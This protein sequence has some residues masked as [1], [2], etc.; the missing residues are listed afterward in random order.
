MNAACSE[1]HAAE[2]ALVAAARRHRERLEK[3][4]IV[5]VTGSCGKTTTKDLAAAILSV[6][7]TGSKNDDTRNCGADVAATL[8]AARPDDDYLVQELGAWGPGTL[9]AGI[10]LMRPDIAVVTN[11]RNDHHSSFHGPHGAQAEKGKLVSCLSPSGIAVLNWDDPLVRDLSTWTQAP[12]L[13]FGRDPA[14]V[15]RASDVTAL[16]PERLAFVASHRGRMTHVR[17]RLV[18]DH[19]LGSALAALGVGIAFGMT[20]DEAA[21]A[22]ALAEPSW[23][24]MSPLVS[25]DG[26]TFIRDDWKAPADSLPE[27]LSFMSAAQARRKLAVFGTISDYPGRSRSTYSR[28]AW[29]AMAA[30]D[31]VIFVGT[32]AAN[33]WGEQRSRAAANQEEI[34]RRVASGAT[35]LRDSAACSRTNRLG[36]MFVFGTVRDAHAFLSGYLR[37]GDLVIVKGSGP[38]DHLERVILGRELPTICWRDRCGRLHPCDMC[39]LLTAPAE[40]AGVSRTARLGPH[41]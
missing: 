19:L 24:R 30:L 6:R 3:V 21:G 20:L 13:S 4:T 5:C 8:L 26:I 15:L 41:G 18:G 17:T 34:R 35:R 12:T 29:G 33:L 28:I 23:R 2:A 10:S 32:R 27:V 39:E 16:W 11:I 22:L 7:F 31:A 25:A 37:A 1:P 40:P 14:A 9:D 38:A 36:E